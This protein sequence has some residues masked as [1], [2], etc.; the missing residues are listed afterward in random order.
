[1][2]SK[3]IKL[4]IFL[5]VTI[6]GYA[7]DVEKEIGFKYVK[8]EYLMSTERMED[9]IKELNDII[10]VSPIY[11]DVLML[12][13]ETRYRLG[14]YK[15]TKQDVLLSIEKV[16][17]TPKAAALLGKA[18]YYLGNKDA[19]LNSL[20][21][22][23]DMGVNDNRIYELRAT[24]YQDRGKKDKACADWSAAA[25]LGSTKGA[26]NSR[27]LCGK[28]TSSKNTEPKSNENN[29]DGRHNNDSDNTKPN[30]DTNIGHSPRIDSNVVIVKKEN[31]SDS[32][33]NNS[34]TGE[35][36][37]HSNTQ[38]EEDNNLP[39][40]DN[41]KNNIV[42]D[43]DLTL[44]IYG[45]GLGTRKLLDRPSILILSDITGVVA[46]EI[47]VNESG[48]V[49]DV[50]YNPEMSTL[51]KNSLVSLAIRK[52]K[53]FWFAKSKYEKQCGYIMFNIKGLE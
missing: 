2:C 26:I 40:E 8:A 20:S 23:I 10:K 6:A 45:Q 28:K 25:D 38:V 39:P 36:D 17:I 44:S 1:M 14:A 24:I 18:D 52:S 29:N 41:T 15:G 32:E 3:I 27:K 34:T 46:V 37:N 47:C 11:K 16:G 49:E 13:A 51:S 22:A 31:H 9:A 42:V 4:F 21:T 12:R 53:E 50:E 30:E 7:Q 5:L 43:E 48:K 33:D 35:E 19:A